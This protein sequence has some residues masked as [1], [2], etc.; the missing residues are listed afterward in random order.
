MMAIQFS[1]QSSAEAVGREVWNRLAA[2]ASPMMEWEYFHA[3]EASGIVSEQRGYRPCHLLAIQD[4]RAIA[5]APLYERDRAWVEFGDGG[6]VELL[7]EVT[8]IPYSMGVVGMIPYTPVPAYDFLH[9]PSADPLPAFASLLDYLDFHCASRGLHT[10]RLY[11]ASSPNSHLHALLQARGY[12]CLRTEYCLWFNRHYADFE[13]YVRS[14]KSSRRTKIRRERRA[15]HDQRIA[16]RMVSGRDAPVEY[17]DLI[18]TLYEN[19]WKKHMGSHIR[20][21][22]NERFFRLLSEHFRHRSTFAVADRDGRMIALALFYAKEGTLYGRYWG[23]FEEV[24]FLHFATCYYHPIAYAI[25]Q[26]MSTV[27]PGFGGEH[28]LLR[29]FETVPTHHYLKFHGARQRRVA[30]SIL[31]QLNQQR[32]T[33]QE[34]HQQNNR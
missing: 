27:D 11:F 3:L 4:D 9:D 31:R 16:I 33:F 23:C 5:L 29:G 19:T 22:L 20:P 8:G 13:D 15:I 10:S 6:L 1:I 21:F 28:K 14:L 12:L 24:P 25:E 7:S 26:G 2:T 32:A 18:H 34:G 17:F 30:Y